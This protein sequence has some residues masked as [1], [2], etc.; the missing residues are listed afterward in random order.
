L[1]LD[2]SAASRRVKQALSDG[3]L[4]NL[5]EK[6]GRPLRLA[7]GESLPA[8]VDILP[9]LADL[10]E[11]CNEKSSDCTVAQL[12]EGVGRG[13]YVQ[14]VHSSEEPPLPPNDTA[15]VQPSENEPLLD[16]EGEL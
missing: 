16:D 7:T 5:E 15:T 8:T 4:K 1:Q 2:K 6:K 12:V 3:Y 9:K 11:K 14:Q 10:Q 13:S